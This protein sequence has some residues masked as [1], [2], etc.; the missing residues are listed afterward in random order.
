MIWIIGIFLALILLVWIGRLIRTAFV[1]QQ[2]IL[3]DVISFGGWPGTK[4]GGI[5]ITQSGDIYQFE[6]NTRTSWIY[7]WL[8]K[9]NID[10]P[11]RTDEL[12]QWYGLFPRHKGRIDI[13]ILENM[14]RNIGEIED[15]EWVSKV[16]G[17]FD[18]GGIL[19]H[20]YDYNVKDKTHTP[21]KL[22][23]AGDYTAGKIAS[24]EGRQLQ[25]W[26]WNL[27]LEKGIIYGGIS[28]GCQP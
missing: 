6:V 1:N 19:F 16:T 23:S 11:Y 13:A 4:S 27:L 10:P 17:C 22:Y 26:L 15:D 8:Y 14:A 3:F 9:R 12:Y 5:F 18:G 2:R 25:E 21:I 28:E 20:A 7:E 24:D